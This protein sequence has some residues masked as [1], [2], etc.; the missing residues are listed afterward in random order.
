M[1]DWSLLSGK[2]SQDDEFPSASSDNGFTLVDSP[3]DIPVS[4]DPPQSEAQV[5]KWLETQSGETM[6]STSEHIHTAN[7]CWVKVAPSAPT[8][9]TQIK[10]YTLTLTDLPKLPTHRSGTFNITRQP[11]TW[12][13]SAI[14][15]N[16]NTGS[17]LS[18]GISTSIERI[19][20]T[21]G[22]EGVFEVILWANI[23]NTKDANREFWTDVEEAALR[24]LSKQD[25]LVLVRGY[26]K[27]VKG[28]A[29]ARLEKKYDLRTFFSGR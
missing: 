1:S 7:H 3:S 2:S 27:S 6:S 28:R 9:E 22:D 16:T 29:G 15:S 13:A 12:Y 4:M 19:K 21:Y 23:F 24:R 20:A 11:S 8:P 14:G 5:S 10:I 18:T 25:F 26:M 17:S